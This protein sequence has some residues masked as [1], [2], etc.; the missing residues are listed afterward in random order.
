V[1]SSSSP[2]PQEGFF[3]PLIQNHTNLNSLSMNPICVDE[4]SSSMVRLCFTATPPLIPPNYST[5]LCGHCYGRSLHQHTFTSLQDVKAQLISMAQMPRQNLG[6]PEVMEIILSQ[7]DNHLCDLM[8]DPHCL[9]PI[10][11]VF[12]ASTVHHI[13]RILHLVIQNQYKLKEVCMHNQGYLYRLML[14]LQFLVTL[15]LASMFWIWNLAH[16]RSVII[17]KLL[18]HL[19]T[20][21]QISA[22]VFAVKRICVRLSKNIHGGHIIHHCFRLFSPALTRVNHLH[23]SSWYQISTTLFFLFDLPFFR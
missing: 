6:K 17:L 5:A 7:L 22:A 9:L 18:E 12:R 23:A 14:P 1:S 8:M 19:K 4:L 16:C 21:E 10:L 15:I 20:P 13:T 2:S 11:A 3:S